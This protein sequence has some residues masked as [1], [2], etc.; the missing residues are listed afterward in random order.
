MSQFL[1]IYPSICIT[2]WFW[3]WLTLSDIK[4]DCGTGSMAQVVEHLP[5]KQSSVP[6]K[7]EKKSPSEEVADPDLEGKEG[8]LK[9]FC[10]RKC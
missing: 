10:F 1:T 9:F 5:T 6:P 7:R 2:S 8:Q 4:P 3:L